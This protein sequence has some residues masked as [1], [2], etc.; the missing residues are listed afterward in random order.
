MNMSKLASV[1]YCDSASCI[2]LCIQF[3]FQCTPSH[4]VIKFD[5]IFVDL[6]SEILQW[7][8]MACVPRCVPS[9][10]HSCLRFTNMISM[11]GSALDLHCIC[12]VRLHPRRLRLSIQS[13]LAIQGAGRRVKH[14]VCLGRRRDNNI[15]T[16]KEKKM[17]SV[18]I[19]GISREIK[20]GICVR[21]VE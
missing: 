15:E 18:A 4:L 3:S 13:C 20:G 21:Q 10:Q 6:A 12:K 17:F 5:M 16:A 8:C 11:R 19:V 2:F 14:I 9:N 7:S 1:V